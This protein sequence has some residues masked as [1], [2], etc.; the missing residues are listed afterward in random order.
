MMRKYDSEFKQNAVKRILDGQSAA[1]VS[2]EP[3]VS[4]GILHKVEKEKI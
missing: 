1:S 4:E 2:R 3:G